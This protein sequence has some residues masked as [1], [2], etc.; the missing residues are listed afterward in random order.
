MIPEDYKKFVNCLIGCAEICDKQLSE[1][2]ILIYWNS[3]KHL[4]IVVVANAFNRHVVN[5]DNGQFMPKPAD[6][7]KLCGGSNLDSA[8][9]AWSVVLDSIKSVG[10]YESVVFG[11]AATM[12]VIREMGGWISLC[13][14]ENK[15]LPF[16]AN[17]FQ[18]RYK[19]YKVMGRNDHPCKL[20][21][22]SEAANQSSGQPVQMPVLIGDKKIAIS[23]FKK[24]NEV[25][26]SGRFSDVSKKIIRTG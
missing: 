23:I 2:A 13:K 20:V 26:C 18:A 11:D 3:L 4:E 12:S 15:E 14:I 8:M 21:G 17:E 5:P 6:I 10:R 19:S 9:L 25:S 16:K 22:V 24:H 7:I 1:Q